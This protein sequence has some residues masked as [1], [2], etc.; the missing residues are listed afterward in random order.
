[1]KTW[2]VKAEM[3]KWGACTVKEL[4]DKEADAYHPPIS[5]GFVCLYKGKKYMGWCGVNF[6][7]ERIIY[8]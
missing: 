3:P 4:T 7:R 8:K 2:K 1:M 5:H 6:A